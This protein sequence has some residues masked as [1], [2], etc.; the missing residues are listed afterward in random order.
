MKD[1]FE[2]KCDVV[3]DLL[4]IYADKSCSGKT[5]SLVRKHLDTCPE[6]RKYLKSI[7]KPLHSTC[8]DDIPEPTPNYTALMKKIKRRRIIGTSLIAAAIVTV[9]AGNIIYFIE[10]D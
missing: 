3:A 6:C 8:K 4:P 1:F 9:I 10:N 7:K 5:A 2:N